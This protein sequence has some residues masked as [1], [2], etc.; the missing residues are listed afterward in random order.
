MDMRIKILAVAVLAVFA[1]SVSGSA[2]FAIQFK[3]AVYPVKIST[4]QKA[5]EGASLEVA[6]GKIECK[7]LRYETPPGETGLLG[8][9]TST[10]VGV[11]VYSECKAFGFVTAEITALK[12]LIF[13]LSWTGSVPSFKLIGPKGEKGAFLSI[14]IPSIGCE[15]TV[16]EQEFAAGTEEKNL[17][18]GKIEAIFK[19]A[20]VSY[21]SNKK[22]VGCPPEGEEATFTD[23]V[24]AEGKTESGEHDA[25]KFE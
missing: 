22:G 15:I 13:L 23:R 9:A 8:E 14:K 16:G 24:I 4:V 17:A 5:G 18:E 19:L 10:V 6:S 12:G 2:A 25:I 7:S 20:K 1:L 3:A 21:K 11:P